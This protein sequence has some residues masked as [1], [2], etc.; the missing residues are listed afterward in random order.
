MENVKTFIREQWDRALQKSE[1]DEPPRLYLPHPYTTPC[2]DDHFQDLY[3][4]DTYFACIGM[5]LDG[6]DDLVR[7]DIKNFIYEIETYGFIPNSNAEYHLNRSQPPYFIHLLDDYYRHTGDTDTLREGLGAAV[8]EY[9]FWMTERLHQCGLNR[10]GHRADQEELDLFYQ[11]V[12]I[13]RLGFLPMERRGRISIADHY[14]AEAES[15]RDFSPRFQGRCGDYLAVDLN[16]NLYFYETQ[17]PRLA[18]AA[19]VS[20]G[21]IPWTERGECRKKLM[22]EY[23][24]DP[25]KKAFMDYDTEAGIFSPVFSA[26]SFSPL[27]A[28][29][30][31]QEQAEGVRSNLPRI[32]RQWGTASTEPVDCW[33]GPAFTG[34]GP[35][36]EFQW[37]YP[38]GWPPEQYTVIKGLLEYGF[39]SDARRLA[40]KYIR[41][42]DK[43]F[44]ATGALWEKINAASGKIGGGEYPAARMIGWSAGVYRFCQTVIGE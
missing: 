14:T 20:P 38:N 10:Y 3:Y 43:L 42:A 7:N 12:L 22:T 1:K 34:P 24:W 13:P 26:V 36:P 4:W 16:A 27:A 18:E 21:P 35:V 9:E 17:I 5:L 23:L 39:H 19:G 11:K 32:E 33:N 44:E 28:G 40:E 15:G 25:E 31:A 37:M 30:A 2:A 41:T 8:S 6:R 29:T